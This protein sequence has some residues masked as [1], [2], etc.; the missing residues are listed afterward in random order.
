MPEDHTGPDH[1]PTLTEFGDFQ[2]PYCASF[3]A[4]AVPALHEDFVDQG[5]LHY[6]Y[7]HFPILGPTSV[8][9]AEASECARDQNAFTQYHDALFAIIHTTADPPTLTPNNLLEIANLLDLDLSAFTPCL[10][11]RHHQ[12]TVQAQAQQARSLGAR[13][14]PA[15][16]IDGQPLPWK[17]YPDLTAQ[18]QAYL[19]AHSHL[20]E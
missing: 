16:F 7:R 19:E 1:P 8:A 17:D 20:H 11:D 13:G 5:L 14:T 6:E 10:M 3:A 4:Y 9:A 18:L 12:P 2:C 15:L